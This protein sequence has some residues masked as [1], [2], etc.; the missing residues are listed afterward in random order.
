MGDIIIEEINY[1]A[2]TL[3]MGSLLLLIASA[4]ASILGTIEKSSRYRTPGMILCFIFLIGFV[5]GI[6]KSSHPKA[7]LTITR[8]GIVDNSSISS[9][10]YIPYDEILTFRIVTLYNKNAI[11]VVP[12]DINYFLAK[13]P[14]VE[15]SIVKKNSDL[16]LSPAT[17]YVELAKDM[18]PEDILTLLEKRLLDYNSL[19]D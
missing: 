19:Y 17:I 12:K 4:G 18:E 8:E 13:H 16:N 9:I 10:G 1:K 14:V 2:F 5:G 6:I 3:M 15:K 11:E 7:L